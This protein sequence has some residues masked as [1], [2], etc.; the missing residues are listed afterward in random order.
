MQAKQS[1]VFGDPERES[2][3]KYTQRRIASWADIA[4]RHSDDPSGGRAYRRRLVEVYQNLIS[5]GQ[6]VLE[7][8]CGGG[9]LLASLE[10]SYG[11]GVD[12][13]PEMLTLARSRHPELQFVLA[14]AHELELAET[15]DYIILSDLI[16]DAWDAQVLFQ[17]LAPLCHPRT[18][19][20]INNYS[21]LW[22]PVLSLAR[23]FSLARPNLP[24][25]WFTT[26]DT[27][28]LLSLSGFEMIRTWPVI[29][30]PLAGK[31]LQWFFNRVL[32]RIWPFKH[33][34]ASNMLLA[35]PS[36]ASAPEKEPTVSVIIPARNEAGNI[37]QLMRRTPEMGGGTEII[38]VEGHSQD[39]TWAEIQRVLAA[40]PQRKAKAFQQ[41]GKGKGDA[42]RLGFAQATGD[43]LMILDADIS[44]PPEYMPRFY[45]AL[46]S[47][48]GEYINGVRLVYPMEQKA[49]RPLN[50]MGNKFFS[51]AFSWVL[52]QP[53]KDTLCG[54]KVMYK[55]DYE[56]IAANRAYFGEFDPFGDFDLIFGAIK[57]NMKMVDLPIR[58]RERTY[59]DTNISRWSHGWLL[60]KML[61]VGMKK[62]K[63][64]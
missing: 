14:D 55:S 52:E 37:E 46:V 12:F 63:F 5:P 48:R 47:G 49:M 11:V 3:Q 57:Q 56:R 8:G 32:V 18:R 40:Y 60:L 64:V 59:G 15:F 30:W 45:Q 4:R 42:V 44:V 54:T 27:E 24:Q 21:R 53:I 36:P 61:W 22:G 51:V 28:N 25:N 50:L 2:H 34:A 6:R 7:V 16:N 10:P 35:R 17:R 38:F 58:Y 31:P 29:I 9:D 62:L 33:L 13:C 19:I 1:Q 41:T 23:L 43:I 26:P 39:D 20:V